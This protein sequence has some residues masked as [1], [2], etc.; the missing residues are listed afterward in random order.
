MNNELYNFI[1]NKEHHRFRHKSCLELA[2]E[3]HSKNLSPIE[4]M[5]DRFERLTNEEKPVILDG[6]Q[7]V[8]MRT[9]SDLP[10]IFTEEEWNGIKDKHYIHELGFMSNLSPNYYSAISSGLLS[11]R[12]TADVY[13]KRAIDNIIKLS[14]KYLQEARRIGRKDIEAVLTQVPRYGARNFREAL[15]FFRILHFALWLE[16]NYHN[17]IGRFDK[18]MYPYLKKD[19]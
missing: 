4:R 16:G 9:V 5:A 2:K 15:Q 7:I 8:F 10:D 17:T 3:Y 18:Y 6:E 11:K 1:V 14:D 19:M 13:G 12:E